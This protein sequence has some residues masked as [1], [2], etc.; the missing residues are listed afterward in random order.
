VQ[1]AT[2]SSASRI[3]FSHYM[4]GT[5]NLEVLVNN[6]TLANIPLCIGFSFAW[7]KKGINVM[8]EKTFGNFNV[9]KL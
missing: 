1:E 2:G 3:H 6:M 9:E 7:W 5:F 8:I 4:A